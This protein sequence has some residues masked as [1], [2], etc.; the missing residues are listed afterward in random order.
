MLIL[1]FKVLWINV[2]NL[3]GNIGHSFSLDIASIDA[4]GLT[5]LEFILVS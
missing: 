1:Y 2:F 5:Y 3:Y 4:K